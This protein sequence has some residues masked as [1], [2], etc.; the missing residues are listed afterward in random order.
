MQQ[1]NNSKGMLMDIFNGQITESEINRI[2]YFETGECI[3][4][5]NGDKNIKFQIEVTQRELDLFKGGA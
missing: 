4:S 1:D 5:I 3:L 2:P